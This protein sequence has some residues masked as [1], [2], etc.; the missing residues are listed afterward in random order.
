MIKQTFLNLP[1]KKQKAFIDEALREFTLQDFDH[2][3]VSSLVKRLGIAKGSFYQYFDNKKALFLYLVKL[4]Y[5][6]KKEYVGTVKRD[7]FSDFWSYWKA[8]HIASLTFD[9]RESSLSHFGYRMMETMNS[10]TMKPMLLRIQQHELDQMKSDILPEIKAG[11]FRNDIQIDRMAYFIINSS[12]EMMEL[13]ILQNH[14][15]FEKCIAQGRP[16]FAG[17]NENLLLDALEDITRLLKS[18]INVNNR[19]RYGYR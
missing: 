5:Q 1:K 7:D 16:I 12:R 11:N 19:S 2:A 13:L 3:S 9:E 4:Q 18:A 10:P 8:T 15:E 14:S 17:K 6:K